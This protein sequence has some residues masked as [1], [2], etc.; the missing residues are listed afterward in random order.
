MLTAMV[1]G[2][3]IMSVVSF[4]TVYQQVRYAYLN[5]MASM[6]ARTEEAV[7]VG[8]W[9]S[10][11]YL[12]LD[13]KNEG[14]V[15]V[16]IREVRTAV[17]IILYIPVGNNVYT[18]SKSLTLVERGVYLPPLRRTFFSYDLSGEVPSTATRGEVSF[19]SVMVVTERN[20]FIFDVVPPT[21]A[22]VLSVTK[23]DIESGATFSIQ[24]PNGRIAAF[25]PYE[26]LFCAISSGSRNGDV[27]PQFD[28]VGILITG[29]GTTM[30]GNYHFGYD[31]TNKKWSTPSIAFDRVYVQD[32]KKIL[33]ICSL[34]TTKE[35]KF[36]ANSRIVLGRG[37]LLLGTQLS[38]YDLAVSL[39]A[40]DQYPTFYTPERAGR[41]AK[42]TISN[43]M[44]NLLSLKIGLPAPASEVDVYDFIGTQLIPFVI[45]MGDKVSVYSIGT[46]YS[47][48]ILIVQ[49]IYGVSDAISDHIEVNGY[50]PDPYPVT[51][52]VTTPTGMTAI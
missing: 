26:I 19:A 17:Q 18:T 49:T 52:I 27:V 21:D 38:G 45:G 32:E 15:G 40:R 50:F 11:T 24:L 30:R 14:G 22:T 25:R 37:I 5:R 9:K 31:F 36:P 4:A 43:V 12:V 6:V 48:A 8:G 39:F 29:G 2:L 3:T 46:A 35:N 42:T 7:S 16:Y 10:G 33:T 28:S 13:V 1:L 23:E 47:Q 20:V 34:S 41:G 51:V 44:V